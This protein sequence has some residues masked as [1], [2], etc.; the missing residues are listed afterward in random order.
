M[1]VDRTAHRIL[2]RPGDT[3]TRGRRA[4][5]VQ[6]RR[7]K[8]FAPGAAQQQGSHRLPAQ[9]DLRIGGR[10]EVAVVVVAYGQL[11]IEALARSERSSSANTASTF[12]SP[13]IACSCSPMR[14][15]PVDT[16]GSQSYDSRSHAR[17][18]TERQSERPGRQG[19]RSRAMPRREHDVDPS[20]VCGVPLYAVDC[21]QRLALGP[22]WSPGLINPVR[23]A[24][25]ILLWYTQL[26]PYSSSCWLA[27]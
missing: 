21:Q 14:R 13:L 9:R 27:L 1:P 16:A 10:A 6:R 26:P 4:Q 2:K 12:R 5:R 11:R 25:M 22:R 20:A 8:S 3:K 19:R 17:L 15:S 24:G 18:G 7:A 23:I